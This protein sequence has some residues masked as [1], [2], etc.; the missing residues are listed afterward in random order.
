MAA[1]E[2]ATGYLQKGWTPIP[3]GYRTKQPTEK[4]WT[5]FQV[6]QERLDHFFGS[7]SINIGVLLG[8]PS[9]GLIDID[10]DCDEAVQLAPRFLPPTIYFGRKSNPQS[11]WLY[12]CTPIPKT[13]KFTG[14]DNSMILELRSTGCQTIFP[15]SVH[16]GGEKIDWEPSQKSEPQQVPFDVLRQSVRH[17]AAAALLLRSWNEGSR[18]D[19]ATAL[20]GGLLR[21]KWN[22][23]AVDQLVEILCDAASDDETKIRLKARRLRN[24]LGTGENTHVP[25]WPRLESL[26]GAERARK[27]RRWLV[28]D[29]LK[30]DEESQIDN[31]IAEMNS[32]HAVTT[33]GSSVRI[34]SERIDPKNGWRK[35]NFLTRSDFNLLYLNRKV[36]IAG[37]SKSLADV[38]INHPLRRQYKEV[39]FEPR[40]WGDLQDTPGSYN[41]WQGFPVAPAKGDCALYLEHLR[42]VICSGINAHFQ[43]LISWMA[44]AIQ[45]PADRPGVAIVLR[46]R[47]G[48]GKGKMV[49]W[50]G[51]LFG[52]H[53]IQV[54]SPHHLLGHFNA[55]L[56][57]KLLVFADEAFWAGDKASEGK[58]KGMI[59]ESSQMVERK[60]VDAI[61]VRNHV[62]LITASNQDWVIP[63]GLEERRFF[64]LDV[65]EAK[66]QDHSYF[67]AIDQQMGDNGL[68]ALMDHLLGVDLTNFNL[69]VIPQTEALL[70]QKLQSMQGIDK[71]WYQ[72]LRAGAI[73]ETEDQWPIKPIP[74]G[75]LYKIFRD[76]V[77]N[78]SHRYC[79]DLSSFAMR[80]RRIVPKLEHKRITLEGGNNRRARAYLLPTLKS[81]RKHFEKL[82][83]SEIKWPEGSAAIRDEPEF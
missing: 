18:D 9:N 68:N 76:H 52:P 2:I 81:C 38:W 15:G 31:A 61:F 59:T 5:H 64:V 62:R 51:R 30:S 74:V 70:E 14:D 72:C 55:H 77:K 60:G 17:L 27:I 46:G 79:P 10:L 33:V 32:S 16:P 80:L 4:E 48:T 24:S 73:E 26:I 34:L 49:E 47:Q 11:H 13:E 22:P 44:D 37:K 66:I 36:V 71:W 6:S 45:R 78:S 21:E 65:S 67:A 28:D 83:R 54:T 25:G 7:D 20:S 29:T 50:F 8:K 53:F 40:P 42:Q 23:E 57:D 19:I 82:L 63:A 69:R 1:L 12:I 3:V 43:Y 35:H 39:I 41:L 75:D 58:L 56:E